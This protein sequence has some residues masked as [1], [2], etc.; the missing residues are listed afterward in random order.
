M[1]RIRLVTTFNFGSKF[2]LMLEMG[3]ERIEMA[4]ELILTNQ[5]SLAVKTANKGVHYLEQ[6]I[7]MLRQEEMSEENEASLWELAYDEAVDQEQSLS[8][9]KY[10]ISDLVESTINELC[11][12]LIVL[13]GEAKSKM[14]VEAS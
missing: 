14:M 7:I 3:S 10:G 1:E 12:R 11:E 9:M 5:P 13:Q 8:L 6:A 2:R 4:H